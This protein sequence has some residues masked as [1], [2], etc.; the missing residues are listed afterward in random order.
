MYGTNN[1]KFEFMCLFLTYNCIVNIYFQIIDW[2]I[3]GA[4][5]LR[6]SVL[7]TVVTCSVVGS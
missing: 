4:K 2:F 1:V 5:Q 3:G 6:L 7:A